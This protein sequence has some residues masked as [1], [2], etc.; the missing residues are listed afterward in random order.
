MTDGSDQCTVTEPSPLTP[1]TCSGAS[2]ALPTVSTL[3]YPDALDACIP[4]DTSELTSV[5]AVSALHAFDAFTVNRYGEPAVSPDTVIG[6][7]SPLTC[8][9]VITDPAVPVPAGS[10]GYVSTTYDLIVCPPS[11]SEPGV[12]KLTI[13]FV[14][15]DGCTTADTPAGATGGA[16]G[17]TPPCTSSADTQYLSLPAVVTVVHVL[18][19]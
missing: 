7:E 1:H 19:E 6:L 18:D 14:P 4:A 11:A 5:V 17:D 15:S 2:G 8:R 16:P 9:A 3:L 10:S 13:A 12:S